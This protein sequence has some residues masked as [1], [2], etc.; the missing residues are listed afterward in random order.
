MTNKRHRQGRVAPAAGEQAAAIHHRVHPGAAAFFAGAGVGVHIQAGDDF[1]VL[2]LPFQ[3]FKEPHAFVPHRH[4]GGGAAH[5]QAVQPF[6]QGEQAV[7][8]FGHLEIFAQALLVVAV[9]GL[10]QALRPESDVPRL[11]VL[12][13]RRALLA[14]EATQFSVF[15]LRH[16]TGGGLQLGEKLPYGF[17]GGGHLV[18][19][20]QVR[21]MR[22]VKQR[23][24]FLAQL[25]GLDDDGPVV[26]FRRRAA[27]AV[28]AVERLAQAAVLTLL[29]DGEVVRPVHHEVPRA[30][31]GAGALRT[32]L[33]GGLR[34]QLQDGLG[35]AG[36]PRRILHPDA[37]CL[38]LLDQIGGEVVAELRQ[39]LLNFQVAAL[40][41]FVQ[42]DAGPLHGA[43]GL[44][45]DALLGDVQLGKG[46]AAAQGGH[47]VIDRPALTHAVD[48]PDVVRPHGVLSR[49][50]FIRILYAEQMADHAQHMVEALLQPLQGNHQPIPSGWRIGLKIRK[51][52][53]H[54]RKQVLNPRLNGRRRDGAPYGKMG[55][56][57]RCRR[58]LKLQEAGGASVRLRGHGLGVRRHGRLR[59]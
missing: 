3:H 6:H 12:C 8:N 56:W 48:Q 54:L 57:P 22:E 31:G 15:P 16:R 23:C 27:A 25:Q 44:L 32:V 41:V 39:P 11:R 36:H 20:A 13:F 43:D 46:V 24:E 19:Q 21:E 30:G 55:D 34:R 7:E 17:D 53:L 10:L 37:G 45:E 29:E 52:L 51:R 18:F 38:L 1:G 47:G 28:G 2:V 14:H 40:G 42:M 59:C 50:Q 5:P 58:L 49:L 9:A 26:E 4:R 35:N 33:L